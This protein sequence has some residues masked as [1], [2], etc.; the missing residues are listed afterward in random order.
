MS[1]DLMNKC[2]LNE[3]TLLIKNMN[4]KEGKVILASV[5]FVENLTF[6]IPCWNVYISAMLLLRN[7]LT[8]DFI[9]KAVNRIT[10]KIKHQ[11][12]LE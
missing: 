1:I 3:E 5:Y 4:G 2:L 11:S 8:S 6:Q 9:L 12:D 10:C 7:D